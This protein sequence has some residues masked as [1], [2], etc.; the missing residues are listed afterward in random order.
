MQTVKV[1]EGEREGTDLLLCP[2]KLV[3]QLAVLVVQDAILG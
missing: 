1:R 2:S 3:L